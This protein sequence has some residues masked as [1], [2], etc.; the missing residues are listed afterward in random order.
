LRGKKKIPSEEDAFPSPQKKK[1]GDFL[2]GNHGGE[3]GNKYVCRGGLEERKREALL[4]W[5]KGVLKAAVL[6]GR[7]SKLWKGNREG[8]RESMPVDRKGTCRCSIFRGKMI[9]LACSKNGTEKG[10]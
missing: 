7:S 9:A 8:G 1:K 2:G 5:E 3:G 4:S 10:E 6:G